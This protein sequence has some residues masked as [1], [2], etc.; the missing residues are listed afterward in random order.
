[1]PSEALRNELPPAAKELLGRLLNQTLSPPGVVAAKFRAENYSEIEVLDDLESRRLI[2]TTDGRYFVRVAAVP[3]LDTDA[4]KQLTSD[5]EKLYSVVRENY[6]QTQEAPLLISKLAAHAGVAIEHATI[7]LTLMLEN[8]LWLRGHSINLSLPDA[9]VSPSEGV[10]KY[11]TFAAAERE[12]RSWSKPKPSTAWPETLHVPPTQANETRADSMLVAWP[13]V[14]ACL[15]EFTFYDIKELVGLAGLDVVAL[16]PLIQKQQGG[17]SKGHLMSAIDAQFGEIVPT[18][19]TRFLTIV[20][21][22]ILRRKPNSE[23]KLSEYLSRLGWAFREQTLLPLQLLD[24]QDLSDT[25]EECH[26]DLL[27]AAARFRDGDFSGSISGACG[28]VDSA[29]ALVYQQKN[30]GDPTQAS[31]QERCRKAVLAK[32]V[33]I[34]LDQQLQSLGWQ[35]NDIVPFHKNLEGAL[36]QGAYVMQTLRSRM[37][38]VHGSKPILRSLVFDC[39]KWAE[40]IVG[41]LVERRQ[42]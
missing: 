25:P 17:A 35:Q 1:M 4:A 34:E 37:G 28:A 7:A 10:L 8:S 41:S 40:L 29:T 18:L 36:N 22:E 12:V 24:P 15:Q 33:L 26:K 30:L 39:L 16:A 38:D 3:L 11:A 27:K 21:E 5:I 32:G 23:E 6:R 9:T 31:F 42:Q 13:A 19:Q 2:G 14:R 20:I